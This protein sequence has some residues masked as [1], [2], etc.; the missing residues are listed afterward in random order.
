MTSIRRNT[1]V[2]LLAN[3]LVT[4]AYSMPHS[5]LTVILLAKGLTLSQI[6]LIQSAYSIA[7]VLFEFPSGLLADN[8]SR[9]NLYSLSKVFLIVMFLI[10]LF[11][12]NFYL[13]FLA[14]FCYGIA[15]ALDSGTLDAYIINQLKLAHRE[16]DL[17]RFLA[18]SN[19]LEI[20]GL[21]IGSSLG[22]ILYQFIGINIYVLGTT[23]LV[24]STLVS[25]FFFKETTKSFGL[26]ESHVT[27]LKKQIQ[28][29]FKE[30]HRQPRLSVILI[31]DF[32][33]QIFFQTH[34]Q[35]WQSFFLSKGIS[36]RYF[37]AFYI[38]FQVIT[39]FSY[40]INIEGIKKHAGLIKF[41]PLIIFLP[42]TFFSGYLGIFLPAYFIF[43]FVFYV[44]E[45]I[46]N[47]HFNKMVSIENISSLVSFKSTVGRL[48]SILLLCLLSFMVKMVAVETVMAINFM[49]SV[50]FLALLGV[51]FKIK[52][53]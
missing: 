41:S 20:I 19:R 37:P 29:S 49:A 32:L 23:F 43:I 47:Y 52:R 25:F 11:S 36:S 13:I 28:E 21:L 16:S 24:A 38:A 3:F 17:Q 22:G 51:F 44:I 4:V 34:F 14:W 30:L 50:G 53:N 40:S 31:F 15:A 26:Q 7:I 2:Y 10:V 27:V 35:L 9:K 45:F 39:L 1:F 46:L 12:S 42:L 8:Y 6:L 48:G 5:I 18:L 33:T